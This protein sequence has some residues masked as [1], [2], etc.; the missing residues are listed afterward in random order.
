MKYTVNFYPEK[1]KSIING[2]AVI[3]EN[4]PVLCSVTWSGNRI[5]YYTGKRCD[6][7]QWNFDDSELKRNQM[8]HDG[9]LFSSFN[10]DLNRIKIAIED[11]FKVYD[12]KKIIP[13]PDQLR[14]DL[15]IKLGKVKG[16]EDS[17]SLIFQL[18]L[19]NKENNS[20][21]IKKN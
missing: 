5:F 12:F 18:E 2:S 4:V 20:E 17:Y 8:T 19:Y 6:F 13:T 11:L 16:V 10:N 14:M 15:N 3:A 7:S 1:R 21:S 9:Q